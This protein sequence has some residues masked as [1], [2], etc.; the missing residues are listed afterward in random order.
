MFVFGTAMLKCEG[1]SDKKEFFDLNGCPAPMK[2]MHYALLARSADG[3]EWQHD[4]G[5]ER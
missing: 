3:L 4:K 1:Y 2:A 5:T